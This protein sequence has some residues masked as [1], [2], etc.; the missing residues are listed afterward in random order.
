[1]TYVLK[2][3][4]ERLAVLGLAAGT[5]AG[6]LGVVLTPGAGLAAEYEVRLPVEKTVRITPVGEVIDPE[7]S[8][9]SKSAKPYAAKPDALKPDVL[10]PDVLKPD[11]GKTAP[12]A[13]AVKAP[14]PAADKSPKTALG[15]A[16][17]AAA[18]AKPVAPKPAASKKNAK[19]EPL[20]ADPDAKNQ[21]GAGA[22]PA[23]LDEPA[24][25]PAPK[26]IT[27]PA[28]PAEKLDPLAQVLPPARAPAAKATALP[29]DGQWVGDMD[30]EFRE[31]SLV[32]RAA[33]NGVVER[34][35]WFN[36][37]EPRKVA[38]DLRGGWLKKGAHVLRFDTGPVKNVI[39]GQHPDRLRLAVEFRDG[40]VKQDLDPKVETGPEG[41][42]IT[43]PLAV[44][45]KR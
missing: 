31:D 9:P 18:A 8:K 10:K 42:S 36:L 39:V 6:M 40:A 13:A 44:R 22:H 1:M 17:E 32:L 14:A 5:F 16:A 34:V 45:L 3:V 30:V 41:V 37:R 19:S 7:P 33:T 21:P 15:K 38:L 25:K 12:P 4:G 20:H 43:I 27:K 29:A 11:A 23:A 26:P 24:P 2:R 35:T 28:P